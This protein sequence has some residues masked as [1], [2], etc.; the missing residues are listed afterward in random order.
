MKVVSVDPIH[1]R[2]DER[3]IRG[4]C[5]GFPAFSVLSLKL[6]E[7]PRGDILA[8]EAQ[9]GIIRG[10]LHFRHTLRV[11]RFEPAWQDA[12]G[13]F[14]KQPATVLSELFMALF[15]GFSGVDQQKLLRQI[16]ALHGVIDIRSF[17]DTGGDLPDASAHVSLHRP[18]HCAGLFF[19]PERHGFQDLVSTR[20]PQAVRSGPDEIGGLPERAGRFVGLA[21]AD[22]IPQVFRRDKTWLEV[23][24]DA[25]LGVRQNPVDLLLHPRYPVLHG[26][27]RLFHLVIQL[28][29]LL[30]SLFFRA[31]RQIQRI[32][33]TGK[34]FQD[35]FLFVQER[36]GGRVTHRLGLTG[37]VGDLLHLV[38]RKIQPAQ[39]VQQGN[40]L[41]DLL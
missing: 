10:L 24:D 31:R 2:F 26:P 16:A 13:G 5:T 18:A 36:S 17:P 34:R 29:R 3:I 25:G 21:D 38:S 20:L 1:D 19:Q 28:L 8:I 7:R 39:E 37:Q 30:L 15:Q 11:H 22:G 35:P 12:R 27:H 41:A 6:H 40:L 9:S 4:Q 23:V 32:A 33:Q 14:R